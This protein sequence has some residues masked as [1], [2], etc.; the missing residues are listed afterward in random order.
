MYKNNRATKLHFVD[1]KNGGSVVQI[2]I[3][4]SRQMLS[5]FDIFA[6]K[7]ISVAIHKYVSGC[8]ACKISSSILLFR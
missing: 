3:F 5:G 6:V 1:N 7:A 4:F 2:D 8:K